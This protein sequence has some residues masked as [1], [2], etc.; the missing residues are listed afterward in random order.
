VHARVADDGG[1]PVF[2]HA[3]A[4]SDLETLA[5]S[6]HCSR[7]KRCKPACAQH[8]DLDLVGD[9]LIAKDA[10]LRRDGHVR[11]HCWRSSTFVKQCFFPPRP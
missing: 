2:D 3:A 10:A 11:L 9:A 4:P 8:R 5:E 7:G 1:S 6:S